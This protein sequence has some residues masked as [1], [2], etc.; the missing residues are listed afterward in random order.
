MSHPMENYY[1]GAFFAR[2]RLWAERDSVEKLLADIPLSE[3]TVAQLH[4]LSL[5]VDRGAPSNRAR[6]LV[7]A[8]VRLRAFLAKR[9]VKSDPK[10][11]RVSRG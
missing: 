1:D 9:P 7:E 8:L 6:D 11:K 10:R 3:F 2:D 5:L 4:D